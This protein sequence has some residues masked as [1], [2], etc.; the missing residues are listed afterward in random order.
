MLQLWTHK[1]FCNIGKR[2]ICK[3]YVKFASHTNRKFSSNTCN[4]NIE[5]SFFSPTKTKSWI[6]FNYKEKKFGMIFYMWREFLKEEGNIINPHHIDNYL[7]K[8]K[9][10][11]FFWWSNHKKCWFICCTIWCFSWK[12]AIIILIFFI[13]ERM[14]V[15]TTHGFAYLAQT[16]KRL[17]LLQ[18]TFSC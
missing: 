12:F 11:S 18:L 13:I 7:I 4:D 2:G 6:K 5:H 1:W 16:W 3:N 17:R 14:D 10:T 9:V 8:Q 15:A